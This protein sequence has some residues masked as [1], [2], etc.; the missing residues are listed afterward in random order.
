M[1]Y[2]RDPPVSPESTVRSLALR[3]GSEQ[4]RSQS[5]GVNH[6]AQSRGA[7]QSQP[8][9]L[10]P[11]PGCE[12]PMLSGDMW[13]ALPDEATFD[14]S[15]SNV[16]LKRQMEGSVSHQ[17]VI[18]GTY[19]DIFGR[20][21]YGLT[22]SA[23]HPSPA[24]SS[25]SPPSAPGLLLHSSSMGEDTFINPGHTFSPFASPNTGADLAFSGFPSNPAPTS[26]LSELRLPS[27]DDEFTAFPQS[28]SEED[29]IGPSLLNTRLPLV[30]PGLQA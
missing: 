28:R 24:A 17:D 25:Y 4:Q 11:L 14:L 9:Y 7:I 3:I 21:G 23:F 19:N 15:E 6:S 1:S 26:S 20:N 2:S 29:D 13:S 27:A 22:A 18:G 12:A 8:P 30:A 10:L 16:D 5:D